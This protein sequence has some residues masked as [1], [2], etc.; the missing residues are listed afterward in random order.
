MYRVG[1]P[2]WKF[3]ARLGVPVSLRVYVHYDAEVKSYWAN[4]PD[5]DGLVVAGN[6]LDELQSEA[7][8]A[9]EL[10]LSLHLE[11]RPFHAITRLMYQQPVPSAA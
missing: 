3:A 9:C 6:T 8:S 10:L 1:L 5:L 2:G 7:V 4:S 11:Q